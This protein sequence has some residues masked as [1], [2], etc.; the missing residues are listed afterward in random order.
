MPSA[1]LPHLTRPTTVFPHL[2]AGISREEILVFASLY[3]RT[4]SQIHRA[5]SFLLVSRGLH[6]CHTP[7]RLRTSFPHS[8]RFILERHRYHGY[9]REH[10]PGAHRV[11]GGFQRG[12]PFTVSS[13]FSGCFVTLNGSVFI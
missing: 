13:F 10:E 5:P 6:L 3:P 4:H 1:M 7:T 9:Q 12:F 2:V 8:P 11:S